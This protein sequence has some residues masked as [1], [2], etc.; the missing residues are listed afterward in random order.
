[1]FEFFGVVCQILNGE[2]HTSAVK[3]LESD[4]R[5]SPLS[6]KF[7]ESIWSSKYLMDFLNENPF[8][9]SSKNTIKDLN[10]LLLQTA[11]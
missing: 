8:P 5:K 10:N 11:K 2:E 3:N 1:M 9:D 6:K 7:I 4:I